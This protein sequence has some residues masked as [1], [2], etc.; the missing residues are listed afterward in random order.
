MVKAPV[1]GRVKT[2]LA[3]DLGPVVATAFYRNAMTSVIARVATDP[4]W[5]TVVAVAPDSAVN[6]ACWPDRLPRIPQGPGDLGQRMTRIMRLLPPGPV[7][8]IGTDVP[9]LR[10]TD[11]ETAFRSLGS[12]DAVFGPSPD[13]GYWLT[14]LKRHPH[15]PRAFDRVRWSSIYALDD[16][17]QNLVDFRLARV[18]VHADVDTAAD[19]AGAAPGLGR[20]IMPA[21]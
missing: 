20:R 13:G 2:R 16:T 15:L 19:L 4:R 9:N 5:Q 17:I 6:A 8:I 21:V 11:I 10:S 18:A 1:M 12:F 14:G 7:V 3:H